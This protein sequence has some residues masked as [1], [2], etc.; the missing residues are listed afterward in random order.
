MYEVKKMLN[1]KHKWIPYM[2]G[3]QVCSTCGI[4]R[5]ST[6]YKYIKIKYYKYTFATN[7][8]YVRSGEYGNIKLMK[9]A[10]K[11]S[12]F[13]KYVV[14]NAPIWVTKSIPEYIPKGI[15]KW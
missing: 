2:L 4:N 8:F 7:S 12:N 9:E 10:P 11:P 15:R 3:S 5:S 6:G 13:A 1:C 14:L